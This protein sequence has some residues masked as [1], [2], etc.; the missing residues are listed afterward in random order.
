MSA[1]SP[2]PLLGSVLIDELQQ[3]HL[4]AKEEEMLNDVCDV[5]RV[6][7]VKSPALMAR[8]ADVLS[9][10]GLEKKSQLLYGKST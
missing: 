4:A 5:V 9:R 6:Q 3:A 10:F 2:Y 7:R 1:L 8:T